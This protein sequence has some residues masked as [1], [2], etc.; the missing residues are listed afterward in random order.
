MIQAENSPAA[1]QKDR[2]GRIRTVHP[3]GEIALMPPAG[4]TEDVGKSGDRWFDAIFRAH[5]S[6]VVGLLARLTGDR[7]EAE[8][9]AADVFCKLA[10]RG[11]SDGDPAPWLYR[12]ASNAGLDALRSNARRRRR[13][14]TAAAERWRAGAPD[15]ALDTVLREERRARVREILAGLKP[16]D[17]QL[18]MLRAEGLAYKELAEALGIHSASVGTLLA[19]AEAEFERRYRSRYGE[20]S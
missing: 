17:A 8:E 1:S 18:L 16:R 6:R 7:G 2:L 19:R 20:E 14:E 4:R 11:E 15:T 3:A 13:E 10:R 12:V 9:I 5:Y